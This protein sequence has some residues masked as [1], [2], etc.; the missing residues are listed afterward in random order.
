[1]KLKYTLLKIVTL[2]LCLGTSAQ[3][4]SGAAEQSQPLA[5]KDKSIGKA[6]QLKP[7]QQRQFQDEVFYFVLPDRF[8]NGDQSN[9]LG[10]P[11]H[12]KKRALSRGA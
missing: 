9:D 2:S 4:A 6:S 12:D 5:S 8:Y 7:Y 3:Y 1:M 11:A 10:A